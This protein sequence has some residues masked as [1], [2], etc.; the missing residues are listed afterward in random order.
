M[1]LFYNAEEA[2]EIKIND[3]KFTSQQHDPENGMGEET[4]PFQRS[5]EGRTSLN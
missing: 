2:A 4:I 5:S 3:Q 1:L